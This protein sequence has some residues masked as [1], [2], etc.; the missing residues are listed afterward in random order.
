MPDGVAPDGDSPAEEAGSLA[1]GVGLGV[2]LRQAVSSRRSAARVTPRLVGEMC[3]AL[4]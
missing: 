2:R 3:T 4:S 1:D